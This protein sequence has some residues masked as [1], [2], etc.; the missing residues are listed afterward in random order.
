MSN[1]TTPGEPEFVMR[2][3]VAFCSQGTWPGEDDWP[4]MIRRARV[5]YDAFAMN[6]R[7]IHAQEPKPCAHGNLVEIRVLAGV[8]NSAK[9]CSDCNEI[10]QLPP[11]SR[12]ECPGCR[13][14]ECRDCGPELEHKAELARHTSGMACFVDQKDRL[15]ESEARAEAAEKLLLTANHALDGVLNKLMAVE[16]REKAQQA[17]IEAGDRLASWAMCAREDRRVE[18]GC[19]PMTAQTLKWTTELLRLAEAQRYAAAL[20]ALRAAEGGEGRL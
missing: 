6:R 19:E 17:V 12:V 15:A 1:D 11:S 8:M 18:L 14:R 7:A 3:L 16:G 13:S 5:G 9:R 20:A 2:I 4:K 10:I